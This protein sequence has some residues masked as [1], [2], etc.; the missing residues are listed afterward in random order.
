MPPVNCETESLACRV[1]ALELWRKSTAQHPPAS[2]YYG[3]PAFFWDILGQTG[4]IPVFETWT[5]EAVPPG[6]ALVVTGDP[7]YLHH[8]P[9]GINLTGIRVSSPDSGAAGL[10]IQI[11][12]SGVALFSAPKAIPLETQFF[13]VSDIVASEWVI[14][15][16]ERLEVEIMSVPA[17]YGDWMGL[18]VDFLGY[19]DLNSASVGVFPFNLLPPV[20]SGLSAE[21][22]LLTGTV[23]AWSGN[24]TVYEYQWFVNSSPIGGATALTYTIRPEDAGLAI[25]LRVTATNVNGSTSTLSNVILADVPPN[26][27]PQNLTPPT[28][29]GSAIVGGLLT[30]VEGSWTN[31]PTGY[32]YQW[33]KNGIPIPGSTASTYVPVLGDAGSTVSVTVI[34]ANFDGESLPYTSSSVVIP[35]PP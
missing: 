25:Q 33:N 31:S 23:G 24:P 7:I 21:G 28:I 1:K 11:Y 8:A 20:I 13:P 35:L 6:E 10:T 29:T 27:V 15:A 14:L 34:A 3:G 5:F 32:L 2:L 30:A 16:G 18:V 22:S 12:A 4:N 19:I 26:L 9:A 17:T